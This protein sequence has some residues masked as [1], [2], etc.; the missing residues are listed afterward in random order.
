MHG[1]AA[2]SSAGAEEQPE[3]EQAQGQG[4]GAAASTADETGTASLLAE[5][6]I[7]SMPME[8]EEQVDDGAEDIS[9]MEIE[10]EVVSVKGLADVA[11]Q[12][13][14]SGG[15]QDLMQTQPPATELQVHH[16]DALQL[17]SSKDLQ[18]NIPG[19]DE[20]N[21]ASAGIAQPVGKGKENGGIEQNSPEGQQW[22]KKRKLADPK[23]QSLPIGQLVEQM[24]HAEG[25]ASQLSGAMLPDACKRDHPASNAPGS[26]SVA[27][28]VE[29]LMV[30][31]DI[32]SQQQPTR[33]PAPGEDVEMEHSNR[34]EARCVSA[35]DVA[36][37]VTASAPPVEQD[38]GP[39]GLADQS[40]YLAR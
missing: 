16:Q 37:N 4:A 27:M 3:E 22:R 10:P 25:D 12:N 31:S 36:P 2:Q 35:S 5:T 34:P 17:E 38:D 39:V 9:C 18:S 26:V 28:D 11:L 32:G 21:A 14:D 29:P 40:K 20:S 30:E 13:A 8:I 19:H 1:L 23:S 33:S 6:P 7:A 15:Q 24:F